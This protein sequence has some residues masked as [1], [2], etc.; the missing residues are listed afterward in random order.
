MSLFLSRSS[1]TTVMSP[2]SLPSNPMQVTINFV[3]FPKERLFRNSRWRTIEDAGRMSILPWKEIR[4][5][6]FLSRLYKSRDPEKQILTLYELNQNTDSL[7]TYAG[8]KQA[9]DI[10]LKV[11]TTGLSII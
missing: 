9:D 8:S 3:S 11:P 4:L 7:G 10:T 1:L 2:D 5:G 6:Y